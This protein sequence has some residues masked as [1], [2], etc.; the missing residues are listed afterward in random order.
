MD[1]RYPRYLDGKQTRL[2]MVWLNMRRRCK[3]NRNARYADYGERG[4]T[5][6]DE[7]E[8]FQKFAWWALDNGYD[9]NARSRK[10]TLD[11]IDND[12]GYSPD[13]CRF[14]DN[15]TQ[16][17][18]KR[19]NRVYRINDIAHTIQEW[20][21]IYGVKDY[22]IRDRIFKLGW[23]YEKAITTPVRKCVKW[24]AAK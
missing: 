21:R 2:Y 14:V 6:C 19:N 20:A 16:C 17:N 12:K 1:V 18:N 24:G 4:I 10:C 7:W 3:D 15:V 8:D 11:R 13:N 9:K 23:D 5:V 22:V